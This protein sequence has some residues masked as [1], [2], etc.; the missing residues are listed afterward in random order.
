MTTIGR[1]YDS[2]KPEFSL[3]PPWALESVAKVLTFGAEKYDIDNW[4]HVSNGDYRYR[5]A[6]LR[7]INDYVKG[8]KNDPESGCNHLAHA[9]CCLM[10]ILDADESGQALAPP[11]VKFDVPKVNY[12]FM[13]PPMKVSCEGTE[14]PY[15]TQNVCL[16]PT[17]EVMNYSSVTANT[18]TYK[19]NYEFQNR[20]SVHLAGIARPVKYDTLPVRTGLGGKVNQ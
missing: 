16:S 18:D 12:A 13:A 17:Q 3:L 11:E 6:A 19:A 20:S 8:E 2:G 4:K 7:H 9:I 14:F 10:F 1:K 15:R 5:N